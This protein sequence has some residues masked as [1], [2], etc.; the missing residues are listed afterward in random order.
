MFGVPL[1]WGIRARE[2]EQRGFVGAMIAK[3]SDRIPCG[4][5]GLPLVDK[6]RL[7]AFQES[8]DIAFRDHLAIILAVVVVK[9]DRRIGEMLRCR[10]LP[11]TIWARESKR[12][13]MLRAARI[14]VHQGPLG[15]SL[16]FFPF[17]HL[18][19]FYSIRF[20]ETSIGV[21]WSILSE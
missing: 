3:P 7:F 6:V 16:S 2:D 20:I 8:H 10:C 21:F 13:R 11:P 19:L 4:G 9:V 1:L 15:D 18:E 12:P 17:S 14:P 5:I